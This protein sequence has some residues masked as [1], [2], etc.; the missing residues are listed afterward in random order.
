MSVPQGLGLDLAGHAIR[1]TS[2]QFWAGKMSMVVR[3]EN[4]GVVDKYRMIFFRNEL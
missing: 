1:S 2:T 3:S 4:R